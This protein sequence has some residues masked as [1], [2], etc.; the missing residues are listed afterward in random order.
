MEKRTFWPFSVKNFPQEMNIPVEKFEVDYNI[1]KMIYEH[2]F[3]GKPQAPPVV[4]MNSINITENAP[5]TLEVTLNELLNYPEYLLSFMSQLVGLKE[6]ANETE[7][8]ESPMLIELERKFE[9]V[10]M[11]NEVKEPLLGLDKYSLQELISILQNFA[12][13]S[14]INY[15]QAGFGSYIANHVFKEKRLLDTTKRL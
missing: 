8:D 4:G 15:N 6:E 9:E 13:N 11:L 3:Y 7:Y 10:K 2:R 14:F 1:T 5:L 12:S